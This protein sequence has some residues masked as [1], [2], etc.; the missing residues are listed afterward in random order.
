MNDEP[1]V[2]ELTPDEVLA[3][4]D[5]VTVV[6]VRDPGSYRRSHA[7]GALS[8]LDHNVGQFIATADKERPVVVICYHGISSV[9]GAAY[10]LQNGFREVYS[11]RGGMA[12]WPGPVEP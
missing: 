3:R 1:E 11:M 12:A 6:D 9:G 4:L 8:V 2:P 5:G 7:P 10:F